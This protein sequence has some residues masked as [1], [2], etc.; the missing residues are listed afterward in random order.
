MFHPQKC[1]VILR[2]L[3]SSNHGERFHCDDLTLRGYCARSVE[4]SLPVRLMPRE[5][6]LTLSKARFA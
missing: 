3:I 4:A 6:S 5:E 1:D 2:G